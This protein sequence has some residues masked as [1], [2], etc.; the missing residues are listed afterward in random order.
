ML[1]AMPTGVHREG[2]GYGG[3]A[4]PAILPQAGEIYHELRIKGEELGGQGLVGGRPN[5]HTQLPNPPTLW[6][7]CWGVRVGQALKSKEY[8]LTGMK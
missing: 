8:L 5:G 2:A 1:V 4:L 7:E 6:A 3:R